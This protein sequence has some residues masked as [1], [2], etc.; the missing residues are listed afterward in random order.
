MV[1][2]LAVCSHCHLFIWGGGLIFTKWQS[3]C[4][5]DSAQSPKLLITWWHTWKKCFALKEDVNLIVAKVQE[6]SN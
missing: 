3:G 6:L 4:N 5:T 1:A 2:V